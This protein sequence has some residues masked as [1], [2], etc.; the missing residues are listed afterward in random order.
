MR[1]AEYKRE[2]VR[3]GPLQPSWYRKKA[4]NKNMLDGRTPP[5]FK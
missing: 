2:A 3:N 4:L 1:T 5:K